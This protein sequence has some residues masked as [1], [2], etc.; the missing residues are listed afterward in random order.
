MKRGTAIGL[1]LIMLLTGEKLAF[2]QS[3]GELAAGEAI[4]HIKHR[5]CKMNTACL[6]KFGLTK[7]SNEKLLRQRLETGK[8]YT[9]CEAGFGTGRSDQFISCVDYLKKK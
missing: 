8:A 6:N 3:Q 1:F 7:A 4:A 5:G 9:I 2:A